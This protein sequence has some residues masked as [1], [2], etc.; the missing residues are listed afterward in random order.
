LLLDLI[1]FLL[2]WHANLGEQVSFL[3][4]SLFAR[5]FLIITIRAGSIIAIA[6]L[7][8][9]FATNLVLESKCLLLFLQARAAI[10]ILVLKDRLYHLFQIGVV[11]ADGSQDF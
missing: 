6:H 3:R 5:H 7:L 8:H 9:G 10:E 1:L 4:A 11:V 2:L